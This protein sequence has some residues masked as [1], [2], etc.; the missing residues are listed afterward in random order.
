MSKKHF[1]SHLIETSELEIELDS[2]GLSTD[3]KE[4]LLAHVHGSIH[5]KVLDTVLSD[6]SENDKKIFVEHVNSENHEKVWEHLLR[7]VTGAQEKIKEI[8]KLVV[9]EFRVEIAKLKKV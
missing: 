2:L 4:E 9:R 6:L 7:N 1:Y 5:Y 3:E 8:S